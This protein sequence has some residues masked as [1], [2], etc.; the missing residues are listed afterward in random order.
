MAD[1]DRRDASRANDARRGSRPH[2]GRRLA[3]LERRGQRH[4]R[5][6]VSDR[7]FAHGD[8]SADRRLRHDDP[9]RCSALAD[10]H[11][12]WACL[13]GRRSVFRE[14]RAGDRRTGAGRNGDRKPHVDGRH[15]GGTDR[16]AVRTCGPEDGGV[17]EPPR[18]DSASGDA[19]DQDQLRAIRV[20]HVA[21]LDHPGGRPRCRLRLRREGR[22]QAVRSDDDRADDR[23]IALQVDPDRG[24]IRMDA[25]GR[26][27]GA[28]NRRRARPAPGGHSVDGA[29]DR[30][31][32]RCG[33]RSQGRFVYIPGA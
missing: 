20:E 10:L 21:Q 18:A 4:E 13:H 33:A 12:G 23:T 9:A 24:R 11:R 14:T 32:G 30:A 2:G 25:A 6:D 8:P 29:A 28:A 19:K 16:P 5:C 1:G 7:T 17:C 3:L 15:R 27:V 26:G 31:G 22:I